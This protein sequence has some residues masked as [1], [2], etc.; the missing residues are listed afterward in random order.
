[1]LE[2]LQKLDPGPESLYYLIRPKLRWHTRAVKAAT[3]PMLQGK[4]AA[5]NTYQC[6]LPVRAVTCPCGG[7][8]C[9]CDPIQL[10]VGRGMG[11]ATEEIDERDGEGERINDVAE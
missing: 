5:S 1:M 10:L 11:A 9:R 7:A 6:Q 2:K 4:G 8:P 3:I